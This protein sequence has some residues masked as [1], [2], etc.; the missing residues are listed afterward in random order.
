LSL[1]LNCRVV[2]YSVVGLDLVVMGG[3]CLSVNGK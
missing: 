2:V 3:L 1:P